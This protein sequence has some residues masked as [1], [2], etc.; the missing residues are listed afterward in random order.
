MYPSNNQLDILRLSSKIHTL[1]V[2]DDIL[3]CFSLLSWN[4][5]EF[6]LEADFPNLLS[7]HEGH[8][9]CKVYLGLSG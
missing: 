9:I 7:S 1:E 6:I 3:T 5:S 4:I 2:E 8:I